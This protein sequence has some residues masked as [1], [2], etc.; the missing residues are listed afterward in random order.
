MAWKPGQSG[1]PAGRPR[2]GHALSDALRVKLG[3][4][5]TVEGRTMTKAERLAE[6][7]I[8]LGLEGDTK[9]LRFIGEFTEGRP[10]QRL[11][12]TSPFDRTT[13]VKALTEGVIA[14]IINSG[15][16]QHDATSNGKRRSKRNR[17]Q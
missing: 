12:V 17:M 5:I 3:E 4:T 13:P 7:S 15:I 9:A 14:D 2:R 11:E 1:N 6:V 16:A 8:S 10:A